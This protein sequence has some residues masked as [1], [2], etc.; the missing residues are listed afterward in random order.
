M[1]ISSKLIA[2]QNDGLYKSMEESLI[3]MGSAFLGEANFPVD[4]CHNVEPWSGNYTYK[5]VN[6]QD[7]RTNL[8]GEIAGT[9]A[10]TIIAAKGNHYAGHSG[11][12]VQVLEDDSKTKDVLSVKVPTGGTRRLCTLFNNQIGMLNAIQDADKK[13][14]LE[15]AVDVAICKW[16]Q[17]ADG[18]KI[19]TKDHIIVHMLPKYGVSIIHCFPSVFSPD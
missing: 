9:K 14:E 3:N 17:N 4:F 13:E 10:G 7:F 19:T 1:P 5:D 15:S 18:D 11:E 16:V 12:L 8:C 6:G 2:E